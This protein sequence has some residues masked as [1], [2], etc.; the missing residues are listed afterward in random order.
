LKCKWLTRRSRNQNIAEGA[1]DGV[2]KVAVRLRI[3]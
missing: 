1:S 3:C 2:E